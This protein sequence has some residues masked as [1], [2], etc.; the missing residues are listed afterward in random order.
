MKYFGRAPVSAI[1]AW[2]IAAGAFMAIRGDA[3]ELVYPM[4]VAVAAG[5]R[6]ERVLK[7]RA[8][9]FRHQPGDP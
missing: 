2:V 6:A 9:S 4:V 8:I 3:A 1:L 7:N 5:R